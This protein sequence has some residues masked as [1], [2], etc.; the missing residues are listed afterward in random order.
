MQKKKA[1]DRKNLIFQVKLKELSKS[2]K[3][4]KK[5]KSTIF[6]CFT[7]LGKMKP[8]NSL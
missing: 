2:F 4:W 5:L 3:K 1:I 6:Y 7:G 8:Q